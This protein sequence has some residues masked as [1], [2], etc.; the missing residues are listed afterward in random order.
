M[1]DQLWKTLQDWSQQPQNKS[2]VS[3]LLWGTGGGKTN[4]GLVIRAVAGAGA[5]ARWCPEEKG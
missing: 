5:G 1:A 4:R 3:G 2:G